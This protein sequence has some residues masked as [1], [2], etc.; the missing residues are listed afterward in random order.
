MDDHR[1]VHKDDRVD[2]DTCFV[3]D[4]IENSNFS[5]REREIGKQKQSKWNELMA[6]FRKQAEQAN[7]SNNL[8]YNRW[9]DYA[10]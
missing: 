6:I 8:F 7:R 2:I 5:E 10:E 1:I 3:L 9:N 4:K